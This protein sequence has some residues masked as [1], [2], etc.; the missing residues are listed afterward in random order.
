MKLSKILSEKKCKEEVYSIEGSATLT[1]AAKLFCK[2]RIGALIVKKDDD[3]VGIITERDIIRVCSYE[4]EFY[5]ISVSEFMTEDIV[6][7]NADDDVHD[8]LKIMAKHTIR[9]I[10]VL[11]NGNLVGVISVGELIHELYKESEITVHDIGDLSG[12]NS[13][14]KVF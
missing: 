9:H 4:S 3:V 10:P 8:A 11:D 1:E 2:Y 14:N 5:K 7:C 6:Y 13:R 12:A